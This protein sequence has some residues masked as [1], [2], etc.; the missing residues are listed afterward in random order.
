MNSFT[1]KKEDF[2]VK[3]KVPFEVEEDDEKNLTISKWLEGY[4]EVEWISSDNTCKRLHN[5]EYRKRHG[6]EVEDLFSVLTTN[7]LLKK[8]KKA[9]ASKKKPQKNALAMIQRNA[10]A[11]KIF[12]MVQIQEENEG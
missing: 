8:L 12:A 10:R 5:Y 11:K 2:N 3:V 4:Y 9:K 1:D 7:D 6:K